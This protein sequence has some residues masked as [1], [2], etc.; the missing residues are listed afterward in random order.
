MFGVRVWIIQGWGRLKVCWRVLRTVRSV[1]GSIVG[2]GKIDG[3]VNHWGVDP[4]DMG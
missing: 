1:D 2:D 3:W 4:C